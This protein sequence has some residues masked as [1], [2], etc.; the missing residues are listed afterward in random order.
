ML[1]IY[2]EKE[3]GCKFFRPKKLTLNL[4]FL[5][6]GFCKPLKINEIQR[7]PTLSL[8]LL[9]K[10][11]FQ[12]VFECFGRF[13]LEKFFV[14]L[15]LDASEATQII[16]RLLEYQPEILKIK[17][18]FCQQLPRSQAVDGVDGLGGSKIYPES[19][20]TFPLA[21]FVQRIDVGCRRQNLI[22]ILSITNQIVQIQT[23]FIL[24]RPISDIGV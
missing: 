24:F 12:V 11:V 17:T 4:H 3:S 10:M 8:H 15:R 21:E 16:E 23:E 5:K 14:H 19:Q 2:D 9:V 13:V 1:Q 18:D 7:K 6:Q 20:Q 22:F